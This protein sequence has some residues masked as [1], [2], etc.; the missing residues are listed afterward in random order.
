[1]IRRHPLRIISGTGGL[2]IQKRYHTD[3]LTPGSA[4]GGQLDFDCIGLYAVGQV[5]LCPPTAPGAQHSAIEQRLQDIRQL[6]QIIRLAN[7]ADRGHLII[8]T[9]CGWIGLRAAQQL[10]P[11]LVTA[12]AGISPNVLTSAW[13][14][15]LQD[16]ELGVA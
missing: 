14:L 6:N 5:S 7:A 13:Q 2:I 10:P 16:A 12:M 9:L 11:E 15:M 4:V 1:L 8:S 3:F